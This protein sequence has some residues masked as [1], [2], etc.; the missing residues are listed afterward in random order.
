MVGLGTVS[1]PSVENSLPVQVARHGGPQRTHRRRKA[2]GI[3]LAI[4]F[5]ASGYVGAIEP[6]SYLLPLGPPWAYRHLIAGA[7]VIA[8][9]LSLYAG[10][11]LCE[12]RAR[13]LGAR[14]RRQL[15]IACFAIV[16]S[17]FGAALVW[18]LYFDPRRTAEN[19][20]VARTFADFQSADGM[21]GRDLDGMLSEI[22]AAWM[23]LPED[24]RQPLL[25]SVP[26][27]TLYVDVEGY[28]WAATMP[29][30]VW[31]D[32][33]CPGGRPVIRLPAKTPH[34]SPFGQLSTGPKHEL[35]HAAVCAMVGEEGMSSI[36]LWFHEGVAD[37]LA[38][39]G[40]SRIQIRNHAK[41]VVWR[42]R[43]SLPAAA[44]ICRTT[45]GHLDMLPETFYPVAEQF[46]GA[47][48]ARYGPEWYVLVLDRMTG[49]VDFDG[50]FEAATGGSCEAEYER[51][52]RRLQGGR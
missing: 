39:D 25:R 10:A 50:A 43:N 11:R 41:S 48:T 20:A 36:P 17:A 15:M 9:G 34:D 46:V 26:A 29:E 4:G 38:S 49:T 21:P 47:L 45:P 18:P 23:D 6:V 35:V 19:R 32:A 7:L 42:T 51:W 16:F 40:L 52:V 28:Q 1:S 8:A 2:F 12:E 3:V 27:V 22:G 14:T 31:G 30:R 13:R 33:R 5:V 44:A 37:F 24:W